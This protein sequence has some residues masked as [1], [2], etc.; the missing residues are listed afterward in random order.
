MKRLF[1]A[2]SLLAG[3][4]IAAPAL[5][6]EVGA[7][8]AGGQ[9]AGLDNASTDPAKMGW[10]VGS[11]P[12]ADRIIS[13]ESGDHL[14][15]PQARWAVAHYRQL[16]PSV[17]VAR[18][19]GPA[20][21]LPAALR[22]DLDTVTFLPTGSD[23]TMTWAQSLDANYTDAILVLHKG[24]IVYER[25][26]GVM[27]PDQPHLNFSATKSYTGT[28]AAMLIAEGKLDENALVA[29]YI[30]ELKDSGFGD[31][32]VRQ[33]LDMTTNLAY[34]ESYTGGSN[35]FARYTYAAKFGPRPQG[36]DGPSNMFDYL[37]TIQAAG[38][39]G[40]RFTYSSVNTDVAGWLVAKVSG[41]PLQ[42]VLSERLWQPL[43]MD[44][45]AYITVDDHGTALA[46]GGLSS[47]LRDQARFGEML[48][49][50][51]KYNGRQIVPA[52]VV[53]D[54]R[55][56]GDKTDF[57]AAGYTALPNWSYRDQWWVRGD[58]AFSAR[59]VLGQAIYVDPN[60]DMVIVRFASGPS[61]SNASYDPTSLPAYQ[62]IADRLTGK[63]RRR[64]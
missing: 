18:G 35:D 13:F 3:T 16:L 17:D 24:R 21:P 5:T 1:L 55:K 60:A 23:K 51:G 9:K 14:R 29:R 58:G 41:K 53:A 45:P 52:S 32:T 28:L 50:G 15:F 38:P 62:A 27:T 20:M 31:A 7:Q 33:I 63:D 64:P 56:G 26:F 34:S 49:L 40:Q 25:Y 42:V 8:E 12:P 43:G 10:M 4:M 54:I 39:H 30:P 36:Y 6:Q 47:T 22:T 37:K 44:N 48:R 57:A 46:A 19:H 61:W 11:P 59:G 2:A